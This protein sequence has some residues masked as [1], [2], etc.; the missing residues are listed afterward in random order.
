M[1]NDERLIAAEVAVGKPVHE[2]VAERVEFLAGPRLRHARSTATARQGVGGD[3]QN[4][5]SQGRAGR[6]RPVDMEL[7]ELELVRQGSQRNDVVGR[8]GRRRRGAIHVGRQQA[9]IRR[10]HVEALLARGLAKEH[11]RPVVGAHEAAGE[12]VAVEQ[13]ERRVVRVRPDSQLGI[14]RELRI[15]KGV[16]VVGAGRVAGL[17]D[18][19]A[20]EIRSQAPVGPRDGEL[21][22]DP[23]VGQS[24]VADGRVAI[25]VGL[26]QAAEPTPHGIDRNRAVEHGTSLVEDRQVGVDHLNV[27]GR[28]DRTVGI[29]RSSADRE[30][31]LRASEPVAHAIPVGGGGGDQRRGQARLDDR[32]ARPRHG[33]RMRQHRLVLLL[34]GRLASRGRNQAQRRRGVVMGRRGGSGTAHDRAV[35]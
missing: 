28:A 13:V 9:A 22:D 15:A 8:A 2:P 17:G 5:R 25:V 1:V 27:V 20:L 19:D 12:G 6:R 21:G 32:I 11:G 3:R 4:V 10:A 31:A 24:V 16:P 26:T 18:G 29:G 14:V 30:R 33:G 23:A 34:A 35:G 7:P